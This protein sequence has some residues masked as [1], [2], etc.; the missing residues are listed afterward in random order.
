MFYGL[1]LGAL[2]LLA[3][4]RGMRPTMHDARPYSER[5]FSTDRVLVIGLDGATFDVLGPLTADGTM[6]HLAALMRESALVRLNS[7]EPTITPTAWTTFQTGCDPAD[8]AILDYRYLDH[9]S[10]Q[11]R[12][13]SAARLRPATIFD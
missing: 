8:H 11:V 1:P 3:A 4:R 7:V 6:P 9:R 5:T 10:G 13:N 12:L 2:G